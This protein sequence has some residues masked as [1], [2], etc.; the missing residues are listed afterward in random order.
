MKRIQEYVVAPEAAVHAKV[1]VA[2]V[3]A[4]IVR[5]RFVGARRAEL[6]S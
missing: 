3:P 1:A 6:T 4:G 2:E 5:M